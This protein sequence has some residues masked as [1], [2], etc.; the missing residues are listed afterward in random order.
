[1]LRTFLLTLF[2]FGGANVLAQEASDD[3]LYA[4]GAAALSRFDDE[5]TTLSGRFEQIVIKQDGEQTRSSG[6]FQLKR[7]G[8]FVWVYEAPYEQRLVAD[9]TNLWDYDVDLD[10]ISVRDQKE[11]LAESPATIL[12]GGGDPL[13]TFEYQGSFMR[14]DVLW[15][16]LGARNKAGDFGALRLGFR[17]DVLI[18]MMLGDDLDQTTEI[19]F[20]D[21]I[22]NEMID[23]SAFEFIPPDGVDI[24]GTPAGAQLP[25]DTVAPVI[26]GLG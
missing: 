13:S 1:M 22:Q 21:V 16:Q 12:S 20:L 10:Q 23:D 19:S 15:V 2:L 26:P 17:D 14:D 25:A 3:P 8:R 6:V 7:P 5:T 4:K 9:G 18:A 24:Y 11:A